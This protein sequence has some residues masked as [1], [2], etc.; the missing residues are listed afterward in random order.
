MGSAGE[1]EAEILFSVQ[2]ESPTIFYTKRGLHF[3]Y[4]IALKLLF[5]A[6]SIMRIMCGW[7]VESDKTKIIIYL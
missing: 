7:L 1:C 5:L 3:T 6:I 4:K 2:R